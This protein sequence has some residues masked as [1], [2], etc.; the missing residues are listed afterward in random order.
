[1]HANSIYATSAKFRD[2]AQ[3]KFF[4]VVDA[5]YDPSVPFV[6]HIQIVIVEILL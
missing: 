2:F 1:M 3:F 4:C 6:I 5:P